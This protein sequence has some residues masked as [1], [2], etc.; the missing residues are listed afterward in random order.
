M[1][2]VFIMFARQISLRLVYQGK[3]VTDE[4]QVDILDSTHTDS[5]HG[6]L[7]VE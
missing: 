2:G 1:H 7:N 3:N 6:F 4:L 5:S